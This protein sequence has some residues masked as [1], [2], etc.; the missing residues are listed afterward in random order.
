MKDDMSKEDI[1]HEIGLTK[2]EA[3]VFLSLSRKN[4]A[5][6][7][8]IAHDSKVH[9][10]NVYD[11]IEKLKR[12][13]LVSELYIEGK[14]I[15]SASH[16][17]NLLNIL[18]E[19]ELKLN[20]ILPELQLHHAMSKK[21]YNLNMYEGANSIRKALLRFVEVQ[22][23]IYAWGIPNAIVNIIGREFLE[24]IHK[25]R[26]KQKQW[27]YHLYNTDAKE[28]GGYLNT[29]PYTKSRHLPQEYNSPVATNVCDN[30]LVMFFIDNKVLTISIINSA[31]AAAYE[32]YFWVLWEKARG[33]E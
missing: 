15:F 23:P 11:S 33:E 13:G 21:D 4:S 14:K 10:V 22:K 28:R 9:R 18:R 17:D 26:A 2:N 27:M 1:L 8:E 5:S 3:Q 31:L 29:L 24:Q 32:K 20:T 25:R 6:A 12:L 30:E 16:P 19:K 7:S